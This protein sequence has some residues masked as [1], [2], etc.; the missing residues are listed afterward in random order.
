VDLVAVGHT[1]L[2]LQECQVGVIGESSPL[3][4][5]A[6]AARPTIPNLVELAHR[7][8]AVGVPVMH[9]TGERRADGRGASANA[10]IF[11]YMADTT[12]PLTSSQ[13]ARSRR[14]CG[15]WQCAPS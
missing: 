1:A 11:R 15:T 3:P 8:R 14:C 10:R 6:D 13:E 9:C 7:A 5:L 4:A 12:R 2:V